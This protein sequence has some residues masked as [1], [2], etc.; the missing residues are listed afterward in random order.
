MF[1]QMR[2]EQTVILTCYF[3]PTSDWLGIGTYSTSS[4][5]VQK[6]K[7]SDTLSLKSSA[8]TILQLHLT[9]DNWFNIQDVCKLAQAPPT[10]NQNKKKCL[11]AAL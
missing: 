8:T 6:A 3:M 4:L 7:I 2:F 1:Q 9:E 5:A 11:N 10:P